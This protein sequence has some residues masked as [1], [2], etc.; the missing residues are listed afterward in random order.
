MT[1]AMVGLGAA[2]YAAMWL[3]YKRENER[4]ERG[5]VDEKHKDLTEEELKE[6]GDESPHYR[7]TI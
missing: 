2:I 3:W 4:R 1:L 5:E 7:Y 6:L